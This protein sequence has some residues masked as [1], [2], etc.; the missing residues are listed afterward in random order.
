MDLRVYF[1]CRANGVLVIFVS[2]HSVLHVSQLSVSRSGKPVLEGI[3]FSL[4]QQEAMAITGSSGTGKTSL[5]LA[6]AQQL[7]YKGD[8]SYT[9]PVGSHIG[10]VEQQHHF[11]TRQSTT[12]LYYQ[13]RFNSYDT[14]E[15]RTVADTLGDQLEA[16]LPLIRE[17]SLEYLLNESLIQLS[18]GENKKL[19]LLQAR[20][21]NP[22]VL[23]MDQPFT[24]L[25][26]ATRSWL[27]KLITE[28]KKNG[29]LVII[30]CS[31]DEVPACI[32]KVL[33]LADGT[34]KSYGSREEWMKTKG[35]TPVVSTEPVL[36]S[37]PDHREDATFDSI[38]DMR[39]VTVKYGE[40]KILDKVSWKV[41]PAECWLLSG[42]NGAGKSTLL[43]LITADN[44]QAYANNIHLFGKKRGTGES[45]WD[46]KKKTGFLSPELHLYFNEASTAFETVAS[47][48]FD[49]IGLFR[50]LSDSDTD[51]VMQWM[52]V[53]N[54]DQLSNK[55]LQE[56]STGEQRV[57]LLA[58]ALVKDP[59]LLILDEPCQAL[60]PQRK[61]ELLGLIN[62]VCTITKKTL[63]FVSHYENDR[64][65]CINKFIRLEKGRVTEMRCE[66]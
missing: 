48:L 45:I 4:H 16:A 29:K 28:L 42:P 47:G 21:L 1:V 64:P 7:Y 35:A 43:S 61:A 34:M 53:C 60:D 13:Q 30:I 52:K 33:V 8:I 65:D 15:T 32:D 17:M 51:W 37:L 39:D 54:V 59:P 18:N 38:I 22:A 25:D 10:W 11:K 40:K 57:V 31:A 9:L 58:R 19:Q 44:P 5:G 56:L 20:L 63:I 41:M 66:L 12:D 6:L 2:M 55:R 50:Q 62:R 27:E 26:T 24:G 23:I 14:E 36:T 49:T 46:I 3:D